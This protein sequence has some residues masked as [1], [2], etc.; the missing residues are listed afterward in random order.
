MPERAL[1][2][3]T[4]GDSP[5]SSVGEPESTSLRTENEQSISDR[6]FSEISEKV[7]WSVCR[8]IKETETNQ[9]E[10]SRLIE[11]HSSKVDSLSGRNSDNMNTEVDRTQS[12]NVAA[13]SRNCET[14]SVNQD[15]SLHRNCTDL[16]RFAQKRFENFNEE[17]CLSC[18]ALLNQLL[19]IPKLY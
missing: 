2:R 15:E 19:S 14:E 13:T 1:K 17:A 18:R 10:I 7:E 9:R 11:N 12:E 4:R 8:R 16:Y 3:K 5:T 6:D